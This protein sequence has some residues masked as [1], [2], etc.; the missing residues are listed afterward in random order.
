MALA[1]VVPSFMPG[2]DC[3]VRGALTVAIVAADG[4]IFDL[5]LFRAGAFRL[6]SGGN[7]TWTW[8]GA[9]TEDGTYSKIVSAGTDGV[10]TAVADRVN[11]IPA[12]C[13][14]FRYV[15]AVP[16]ADVAATDFSFRS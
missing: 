1:Q 13:F 16:G 12:A 11:D 15:K 4:I 9:A 3:P 10:Q 7:T 6:P 8:Y 2:Y 5:G 14:N